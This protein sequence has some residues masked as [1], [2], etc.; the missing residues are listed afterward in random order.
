MALKYRLQS[1]P[2]VGKIT[3]KYLLPLGTRQVGDDVVFFN[4]GYEEDPPLGLQLDPADEP[5]RYCIQL[6]HQTASQVDL[7]GKKVLEVSCGAGGGASYIARKLGPA[8]YTGL[9][10]NP[11]SIDLCKRMHTVRGLDFVQGDAQH[12]PFPD[13][14]F[15]AVVNVEASHQYPDF[16]GFLDEVT[17]V[18]RPGGHFL[19][20]D[21]RRNPVVGEW[22]TDLAGIKLRKLAQRD[23]GRE[24]KRGLDA[25]TRRSQEKIASR[26]PAFLSSLTR[27]AVSMLDRDL[28]RGGGFTYRIYLFEKD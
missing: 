27:Y 11:A 26:A 9:D 4:F 17:R 24:A 8:S 6:Y 16:A 13:E 21:S 25:N 14:S 23:I 12:L 28:E 15:D 20:T 7:T 22:E 3:T 5:N 2:L 10:L 18:L 1:N 19:Y